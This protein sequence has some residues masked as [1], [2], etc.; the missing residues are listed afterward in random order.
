GRQK[1]LDVRMGGVEVLDPS[2]EKFDVITLS[3]VIEHVH[4][5]VEVLKYCY[6]LLKPD[7][8]LW[9]ETPN[10]ESEGYRLFGANW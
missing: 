4:Q 10:I 3:H 9:L 5:P 7:G 2:V 8:F 6:S 1:G